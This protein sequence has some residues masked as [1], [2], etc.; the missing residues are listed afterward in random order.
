MNSRVEYWLPVTPGC[1]DMV[2]FGS[3]DSIPAKYAGRTFY[4]HN[5]KVTLARRQPSAPNWAVSLRRK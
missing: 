2:N 5:P 1:L 3:P 4:P